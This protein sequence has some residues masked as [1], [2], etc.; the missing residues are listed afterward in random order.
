[1]PGIRALVTQW[2]RCYT[3]IILMSTMRSRSRFVVG[4]S[5]WKCKGRCLA[6][7]ALRNYGAQRM[8]LWTLVFW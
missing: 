1:M 2:Q 6:T 7:K 8:A 3:K 5:V 4:H